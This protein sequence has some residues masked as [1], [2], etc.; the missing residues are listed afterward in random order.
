MITEFLRGANGGLEL[1]RIVGALGSVVF[2]GVAQ[3][4]AI[5]TEASLTEYCLAFA[6]GLVTLGLG[7]AGAIA[8]KDRSVARAKRIE[9]GDEI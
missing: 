2:I 5:R 9:I 6:G 1:N 3:W 7:S 4:V 8:V